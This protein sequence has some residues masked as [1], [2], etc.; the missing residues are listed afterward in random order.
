MPLAFSAIEVILRGLLVGFDPACCATPLTTVLLA[1]APPC[2][3][4]ALGFGAAFA[5]RLVRRRFARACVFI[6]GLGYAV[7]GTV[8]ALGLLSPLVAVDEASTALTRAVGGIGVGLVLAGSSAAV[9][10]AYVV[11]FLAIA[12]GF[13]QAG[14]ARISTE[15]D[16]AARMLGTRPAAW[17][18]RSICR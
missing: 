2:S 12:T 9:V 11:R 16:D 18:G 17:S 6:A 10:I 14:L 13:A 1:A 3:T 15:L 5:L 8:L 4:L 7:P